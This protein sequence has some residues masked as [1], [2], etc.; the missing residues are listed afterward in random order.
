M[1]N[2]IAELL[3]Q[4]MHFT[5]IKGGQIVFLLG[6]MIF[7]GS[8]G[9]RFF[10]K[11]KIPQVVGY[12]VTGIIIGSSGFKVLGDSLIAALDPVST[13]AL[14]LIGFLVGAELKIDVIKK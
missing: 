7:A 6:M 5:M 11:L 14:S 12:I 10:Q 2:P 13:V 4:A 3:P 8:F 9:G 1:N